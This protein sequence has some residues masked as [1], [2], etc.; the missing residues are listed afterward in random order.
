MSAKGTFCRVLRLRLTCRFF[1]EEGFPGA[2]LLNVDEE[3]TVRNE[4]RDLVDVVIGKR[5][6]WSIGCGVS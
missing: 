6:P 2:A 1:F 4:A 5:S 3:A